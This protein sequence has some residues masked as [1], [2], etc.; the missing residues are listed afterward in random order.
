[1]RQKV[2]KFLGFNNVLV[3]FK[4]RWALAALQLTISAERFVNLSVEPA[5][6]TLTRH[7]AQSTN[8]ALRNQTVLKKQKAPLDRRC[9]TVLFEDSIEFSQNGCDNV[10]SK[11]IYKAAVWR[12]VSNAVI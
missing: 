8:L 11:A 1:M 12:A 9:P 3:G 6:A 7:L 10:Y 5:F 4:V 2:V